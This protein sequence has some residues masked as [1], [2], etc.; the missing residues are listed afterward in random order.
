MDALDKYRAE[1]EWRRKRAEMS[2]WYD[3]IGPSRITDNLWL[4]G[5][6]AASDLWNSNPAG[7]THVLDVSTNDP[8]LEAEGINYMHCPFHDGHD[9]PAD[10]FAAAMAFLS[11]ANDNGGK[12]LVHCAAGISRSPVIVASFLH[13]SGQMEFNTAIDYVITKRRIVNPAVAV[14]NSAR[15]L[16]GA[17]PYDGSMGLKDTEANKLVHDTVIELVVNQAKQM[18]PALDCPVRIMLLAENPGKVGANTPRHTI[19]CTCRQSPK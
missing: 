13:Y 9:I 11:F 18:H 15:K 16:L 3:A 2:E 6:K 10:K 5:Y 1:M 7:I 19:K 12:I 17:W 8:Y 4:S 14:I